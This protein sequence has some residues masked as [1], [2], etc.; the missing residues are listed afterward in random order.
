MGYPRA[1]KLKLSARWWVRVKDK[2][3]IKENNE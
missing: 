1:V 3:K 2:G